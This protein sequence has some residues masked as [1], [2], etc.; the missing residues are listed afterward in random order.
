M[1]P[2]Q[3]LLVG[4]VDIDARL[5][6]QVAALAEAGDAADEPAIAPSIR[7]TSNWNSALKCSARIALKKYVLCYI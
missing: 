2:G 3:D 1:D 6:E 4:E 5:A 7:L